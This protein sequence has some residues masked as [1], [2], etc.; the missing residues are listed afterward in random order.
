MNTTLELARLVAEFR[1]LLEQSGF[2]TFGK[3]D[4]VFWPCYTKAGFISKRI[5]IY[6]EVEPQE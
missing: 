3:D 1:R 4:Q 2:K 6:L 5:A